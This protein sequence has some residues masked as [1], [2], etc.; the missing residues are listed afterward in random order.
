MVKS[1][2]DG[3][4]VREVV[5][6]SGSGGGG[7]GVDTSSSHIIQLFSSP[8]SYR[9]RLLLIAV[10]LGLH[11]M[12]VRR[13]HVVCCPLAGAYASCSHLY[14]DDLKS[15]SNN[16]DADLESSAGVV[17][18]DLKSSDGSR[19]QDLLLAQSQQQQARHKAKARSTPYSCL[20]IVR[21]AEATIVALWVV[22]VVVEMRARRLDQTLTHRYSDSRSDSQLSFTAL[23]ILL[24]TGLYRSLTATFR[25]NRPSLFFATT[26]ARFALRRFVTFLK[27][28]TEVVDL[29]AADRLGFVLAYICFYKDLEPEEPMPRTNVL[30]I[31]CLQDYDM[32][33]SRVSSPLRVAILASLGQPAK[34]TSTVHSSHDMSTGGHP[35]R[36][37]AVSP[38]ALVQ[39]PLDLPWLT[40]KTTENRLSGQ[41]RMYQIR[42]P[43]VDYELGTTQ[44]SI[45][46]KYRFDLP[47][48]IQR[49]PS[50]IGNLVKVCAGDALTQKRSKF[51]NL[52]AARVNKSVKGGKPR[53]LLDSDFRRWNGVHDHRSPALPHLET[54]TSSRVT[55]I[56]GNFLQVERGL[57]G[58]KTSSLWGADMGL[59]QQ[60]TTTTTGMTTT[61]RTRVED[62][63]TE[64]DDA[65]RRRGGG[66][67][68]GGSTDSDA[69]TTPTTTIGTPTTTT[70]APTTI[71]TT[72][73]TTTTT[74]S[75]CSCTAECPRAIA[76]GCLPSMNELWVF[77]GVDPRDPSITRIV[78]EYSQTSRVLDS[79]DSRVNAG[80]VKHGSRIEA[81]GLEYSPHGSRVRPGSDSLRSLAA[82]LS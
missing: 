8:S 6:G 46:K 12:V 45:I 77:G 1:G 65:S 74:L 61:T 15:V 48:N 57:A 44:K 37:S 80:R 34:K 28:S 40:V 29:S 11:V 36:P 31:A 81:L 13:R 55:R 22:V 41:T 7:C 49:F 24:T 32:V 4:G 17:V 52:L 71:I 18:A 59:A 30:Y 53:R 66:G 9:I 47:P 73:P 79:F 69:L 19:P 33:D 27:L 26:A 82:S 38:A 21:T 64:V 39:P 16:I 14:G 42:C 56:L 75:L 54:S 43:R 76:R 68:G 50:A 5:M 3:R 23:V 20:T 70:T 58:P 51:K 67:G 62:N 63:D 25:D 35:P 60:G 72:S 2:E 10:H 78:C